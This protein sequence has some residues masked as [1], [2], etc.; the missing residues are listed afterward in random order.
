V[1][2]ENRGPDA[3]KGSPWEHRPWESEP[4]IVHFCAEGYLCLIQR[5]AYTGCYCGYVAVPEEH[6][7]YGYTYGQ[8]CEALRDLW[9]Q[10]PGR[11]FDGE[12]SPLLPLLCH[13]LSDDP[14][15]HVTL[16]MAIDAHG[17]ITYSES[18]FPVPKETPH[19]KEQAIWVLGFDCAHSQ[20]LIPLMWESFPEHLRQ[21][22]L[23]GEQVA[24]R[25][26]EYVENEV[27]ALAKQ[28]KEL[29]TIAHLRGGK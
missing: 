10:R 6:P 13:A 4:D 15:N 16:D 19:V 17:G 18:A 23:F 14:D 29:E 22:S 2:F 20:D 5:N 8:H 9:E 24:Y 3:W 11:G 25:D 28:L 7:V 26:L 12:R 1:I 21:G 27:R